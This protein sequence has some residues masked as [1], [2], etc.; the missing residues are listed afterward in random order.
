[1]ANSTQQP[2]LF[3]AAYPQ[4]QVIVVPI[5]MPQPAAPAPAPPDE[6]EEEEVEYVYEE[7]Q[8][9]KP[10]PIVPVAIL[11]GVG[12]V[13]AVAYKQGYL[14]GIITWLREKI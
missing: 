2:P 9:K 3:N 1:M 5:Q 10:F 14:D 12:I 13:G 11:A 4:P 8:P 6:D 7:G